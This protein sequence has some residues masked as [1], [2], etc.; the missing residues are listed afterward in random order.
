MRTNEFS[1]LYTEHAPSLY[2]F[3]SYRTGNAV[4][5]EDLLADT[6][7]RVLRAPRGYDRSRG[8]E[9]TWLYSIALNCVR[10]NARRIAAET[11]AL[12]WVGTGAAEA[13]RLEPGYDDV[14]RRDSLH[15]ALAALTPPE[16]E[17][18]AL[19]YGGD[20]SLSD[21]ATVV[22]EPRTKVESRIY[23]G[24]KKLREQLGPDF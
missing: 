1:Q 7:E 12:A 13:G 16:L 19:R 3:L 5:A 23:R 17:A 18:V 15:D 24:L 8:S 10:D 20:L 14:E 21:I 2:A 4:L 11:R 22:N 9:R 6:F